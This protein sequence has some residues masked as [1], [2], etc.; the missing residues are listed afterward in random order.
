MWRNFQEAVRR[1]E[2]GYCNVDDDVADFGGWLMFEVETL[3]A[4]RGK[5]DASIQAIENCGK[6]G[7]SAEEAAKIFRDALQHIDIEPLQRELERR[8]SLWFRLKR[9]W[10][11]ED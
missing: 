8:A 1:L 11:G 4:T 7:V 2:N 5:G 9:W 3:R 6:C 10:R